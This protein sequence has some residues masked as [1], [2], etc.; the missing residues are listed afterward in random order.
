MG[1]AWG[2]HSDCSIDA[3]DGGEVRRA[4]DDLKCGETL[5]KRSPRMGWTTLGVCI[6]LLQGIGTDSHSEVFIRIPA[7]P[8]ILWG[9]WA[10][11]LTPSLFRWLL[12]GMLSFSEVHKHSHRFCFKE[13]VHAVMGLG[14]PLKRREREKLSSE[15]HSAQNSQ[16]WSWP[17]TWFL[18]THQG[19][20]HLLEQTHVSQAHKART[21][22][23]ELTGELTFTG[24][25]ELPHEHGIGTGS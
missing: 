21:P 4:E 22:T 13:N 12:T 3:S 15:R 19:G 7:M 23:Y 14:N 20:S 10:L 24:T 2:C 5:Q 25:P 16:P 11:C 17:W 18:F 8:E 6:F 9:P 1:S